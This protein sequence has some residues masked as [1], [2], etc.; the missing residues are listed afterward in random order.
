MAT[1]SGRYREPES[2]MSCKMLVSGRERSRK[3]RTEGKT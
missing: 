1:G 3:G 2:M